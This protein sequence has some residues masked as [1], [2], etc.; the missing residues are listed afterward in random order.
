[1]TRCRRRTAAASRLYRKRGPIGGIAGLVDPVIVPCRR[2]R[3]DPRSFLLAF[4]APAM[5]ARQSL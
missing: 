1:M 2:P 4:G 3:R 5:L